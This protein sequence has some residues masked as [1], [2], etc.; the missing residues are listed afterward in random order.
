MGPMAL[1]FIRL[2]QYGSLELCRT[3]RHVQYLVHTTY[4]TIM[5]RQTS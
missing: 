3:L 4:D 5:K 1:Q 2:T